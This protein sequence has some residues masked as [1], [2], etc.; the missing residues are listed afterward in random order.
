MIIMNLKQLQNLCRGDWDT[1]IAKHFTK[2]TCE[3]CGN[4][5]SLHLHHVRTFKEI[6]DFGCNLFSFNDETTISQETEQ[7]FRSWMLGEQLKSPMKTLCSDCHLKAHGKTKKENKNVIKV[8]L[9]DKLLLAFLCNSL[10][11]KN[12]YLT[13]TQML[14]IVSPNP[15]RRDRERLNVLTNAPQKKYNYQEYQSM[16][17]DIDFALIDSNELID[18]FL[19]YPRQF[20]YIIEIYYVLKTKGSMYQKKLFNNVSFTKPTFYNQN[21]D[22]IVAECGLFNVEYIINEYNATYKIYSLANI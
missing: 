18:A 16:I 4:K 12:F 21:I 9:K 2:Q 22:S 8:K 1:Y 20:G 19:N 7:I 14:D 3:D 13:T 15:S 17:E 5:E 10:P 11:N 6:F